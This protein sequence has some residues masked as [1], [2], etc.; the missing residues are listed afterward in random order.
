MGI[1]ILGIL[2]GYGVPT[3][4]SWLEN[5]QIRT[6]AESVLNGL[7]LARAEAARRNS[8]VSFALTGN[9]WSVDMSPMGAA[10]GVFY[11]AASNVQARSGTEGTRHAVITATLN[12][13]TFNGLGR[14]SPTP[15]GNITFAVTNPTGGICAT[16][17]DPT[18]MRCLNVVVE[19]GGK[20]LMCDPALNGGGNPQACAP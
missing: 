20:I 7:Q 18:G 13:L 2:V 16:T 1:A 19:P 17:V 12:T 10:S 14:V 4:R 6:A 11:T 3:Y 8:S 15:A 9:N 5:S